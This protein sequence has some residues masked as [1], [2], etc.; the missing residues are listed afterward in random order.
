MCFILY[1]GCIPIS[2]SVCNRSQTADESIDIDNIWLQCVDE[3]CCL[4]DMIGAED[5]AE[6]Y[7]L[8]S[9][10]LMKEVQEVIPL[11]TMRRHPQYLGDKSHL[12]GL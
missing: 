12:W 6:T 7:H 3:V 1:L 10:G 11:L 9:Y 4:S 8:E 5:R 2:Y